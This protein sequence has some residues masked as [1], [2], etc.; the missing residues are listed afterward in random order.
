MRQSC[1]APMH[2]NLRSAQQ[3]CMDNIWLP[4]KGPDGESA[5]ML[6]SN[7]SKQHN[8]A[9]LHDEDRSGPSMLLQRCPLSFANGKNSANVK[10]SA[11]VQSPLSKSLA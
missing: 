7:N 6:G 9:L 5:P 10:S 2:H 1:N 4:V 3:H 8:V 11:V